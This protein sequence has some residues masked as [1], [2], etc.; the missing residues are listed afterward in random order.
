M[1][2]LMALLYRVSIIQSG[3]SEI[4][5]F[6]ARVNPASHSMCKVVAVKNEE[7]TCCNVQYRNEGQAVL[8]KPLA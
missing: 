5:L 4:Q 8:S 1:I 2:N 3:L 6:I 7:V